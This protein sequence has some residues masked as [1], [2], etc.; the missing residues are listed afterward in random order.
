MGAPCSFFIDNKSY[1]KPELVRTR[2]SVEKKTKEKGEIE[3]HKNRTN[4]SSGEGGIFVRF[5]GCF[6]SSSLKG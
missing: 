4:L 3:A 5:L 1:G 2:K 6:A